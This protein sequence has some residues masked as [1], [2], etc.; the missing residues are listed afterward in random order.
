MDPDSAAP[1]GFYRS[2]VGDLSLR[3]SRVVGTPPAGT[4]TI[5]PDFVIPGAAEVAAASGA[6]L[7]KTAA[8][9]ADPDA[10]PASTLADDTRLRVTAEAEPAADGTRIFGVTVVGTSAKGFVRGSAVVP[11]DSANVELWSLDESASLLSPN[12]DGTND[13]FVVAARLSEPA[14]TS[15]VVRNAAGGKVRSAT[16]TSDIVRFAWDL[17]LASGAVAPDGAYT[18]TPQGDGSLGQRQRGEDRVV[19][20]RRNRTRH[21]GDLRRDRRRL[22]LARLAAG[23]HPPGRRRP[24]RRQAGP[25]ASRR[26]RDH[27][28]RGAPSRSPPT[29]GTRSSTGRSTGPASARGGSR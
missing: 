21:Q 17:K 25:M 15:L 20:H 2:L 6:G 23:D 3:A 13:G 8:A 11:R 9:A 22:G 4:G 10:T 12:G 16:L 18:W 26:W 29:A 19:H 5:P 24:V 1:A 28:L 7:F 14:A 27:G